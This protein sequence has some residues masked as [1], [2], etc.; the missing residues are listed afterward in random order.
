[1]RITCMLL[2]VVNVQ[3]LLI[4]GAVVLAQSAMKH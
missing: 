3:W 4:A 1:M 2:D